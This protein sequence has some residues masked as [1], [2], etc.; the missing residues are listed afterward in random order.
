MLKAALV[1]LVL[2]VSGFANA[3]LIEVDF[4]FDS[5]ASGSF[6]FDSSLDG[7]TLDFS[8]LLSFQLDF[9]GLTNSSYDL[10]FVLSGNSTVH[11]HLLFDTSNDQFLSATLS[12]FTTILADIKNGFNQGFW[13]NSNTIR[14]YTGGAEQ[15][16]QSLSISRAEQ[17]PEPSTL[18]IF[19]LGIMGLASR[20][21]KKQ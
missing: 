18:A 5:I 15:Q 7:T 17:V 1:G 21:F 11:H 3:G 16:Y 19:A 20:R 14:D 9:S 6:T 12:G 13:V 10:A 4:Q 2:S 8:D